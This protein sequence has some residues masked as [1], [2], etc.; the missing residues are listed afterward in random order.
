M[1]D[2]DFTELAER[3][4]TEVSVYR[5]CPEC[6]DMIIVNPQDYDKPKVECDPDTCPYWMPECRCRD[7]ILYDD[8]ELEK[9]TYPDC[10][11]GDG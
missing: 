9:C 11:C 1:N 2:D 5:E 8:D 7:L 6:G 3:I 4:G 10:E